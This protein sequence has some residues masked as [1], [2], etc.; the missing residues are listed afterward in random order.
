MNAK[1]VENFKKGD[2]EA[3]CYSYA[4]DAKIM[5]PGSPTV[6]GR[7]AIQEFWAEAIKQ[8]GITGISIEIFDFEVDGKMAYDSGNY[9]LTGNSGP[10]DE[11][12]YIMVWKQETDGAWKYHYDIWNNN[13][14]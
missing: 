8:L 3:A 6:H 9:V 10:I 14:S 4:D 13:K 5:P 12:K 11:G 1:F 2:I 7:P